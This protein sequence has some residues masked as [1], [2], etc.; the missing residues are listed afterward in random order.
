[1]GEAQ[2]G[3][4]T[5]NVLGTVQ[6][7]LGNHAAALATYARA[8]DLM[9]EAGDEVSAALAMYNMAILHED[10]REYHPALG[11][12]EEVV[13]IDERLGLPDLRQDREALDRIRRKLAAADPAAE[14][15]TGRP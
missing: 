12:L 8:R 9:L 2:A 3:A 10:R 6:K 5:L 4:I 1:M 11:L 7:K 13:R 15:P 14:P